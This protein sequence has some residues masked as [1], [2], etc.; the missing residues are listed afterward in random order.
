M[1]ETNFKFCT[2]CGRKVALNARF[3]GGCGAALGAKEKSV[4][5]GTA[6]TQEG[7][8]AEE[9]ND[10]GT[11]FAQSGR[12]QEAL[13]CYDKALAIDPKN[14]DVQWLRRAVLDLMMREAWDLLSA[15][16][17]KQAM[18]VYH[19]ALEID[20][21]LK[22][23]ALRRILDQALARATEKKF[24]EAM[25]YVNYALK[26]DPNNERAYLVK[27]EVSRAKSLLRG[28]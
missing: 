15:G 26:L 25:V 22:H 10:K 28:R 20:P 6:P 21:S 23:I 7:L 8:T 12:Y 4:Q 19:Q 9:W 11:A 3:C 2:A 1:A 24:D 16:Q 18:N 5:S 14:A 17:P 27:Q 13:Q